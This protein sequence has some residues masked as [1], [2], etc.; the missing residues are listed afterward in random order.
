MASQIWDIVYPRGKFIK[1][2]TKGSITYDDKEYT[3][4]HLY[5]KEDETKEQYTLIGK[6][7]PLD[8]R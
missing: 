4:G 3:A 7:E 8:S 1:Y 6:N 5:Y 2:P